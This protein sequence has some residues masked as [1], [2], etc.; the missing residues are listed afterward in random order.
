MSE[1]PF[2]QSLQTTM[3]GNAIPIPVDVFGI[4]DIPG[5]LDNM[6]WTVSAKLMRR[7][8]SIKPAYVM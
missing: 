8:F 1:M 4:D 6:G 2:L 5:A 7:W 3:M